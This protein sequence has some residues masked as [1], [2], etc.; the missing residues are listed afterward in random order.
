M[1]SFVILLST[2]LLV[3]AMDERV[4]GIL[5]S[6]P[7]K[8]IAVLPLDLVGGNPRDPGARRRP[9]GLPGRQA[10]KSCPREQDTIRRPRQRSTLPQGRRPRLGVAG[11]WSDHRREKEP[12][13]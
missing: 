10:L 8:H 6:S 12:A 11:I 1:I 4:Q 7:E 13:L 5:F 2:L 9:H 3:P